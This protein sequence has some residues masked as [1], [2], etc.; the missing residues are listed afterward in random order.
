M[1]DQTFLLELFTS[2]LLL[3]DTGL[4]V[5]ENLVRSSIQG[6]LVV[7]L[8]RAV[9]NNALYSVPFPYGSDGNPY[10]RFEK[11]SVAVIPVSGMM[12]KESYYWNTY[13]CDELA[14]LLRLADRSPQIT[15]TLLLIDTPG[16]TT[17]A[18]IQ[19]EDALRT[20]TKPCIG[21]ID[22]SCCSGGIYIASFCDELYAMNRMCEIGSIGVYCRIIDMREMEKKWGFRIEEIYPPESKYKNLGY[23]E[24]LEGKPERLIREELT[25]YA[26][27]FQNLIKENRATLDTSVDG[28]LQ[29]RVF[30]AYDAVANGL[31]DGIMNLEKATERVLALSES[32]KSFYS[33]FK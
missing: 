29:G 7:E 20:R 9:K 32:R 14:D 31:I 4:S 10:D 1:P 18:T 12:L 26:I 27:H 33:Q 16:G 13:G 15:G 8:E 6:S 5:V 2:I 11:D 22:G 30:Y 17:G 19:L 25:P 28:I 3:R 23:R 24:A 21:L